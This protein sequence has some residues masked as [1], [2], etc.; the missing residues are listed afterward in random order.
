MALF[1]V[2]E[3]A[4][5]PPN[6]TLVA[7]VKL[8]PVITTLSPFLADVGVNEM[9]VGAGIKVN[10]V[11]VAAPPGVVTPTLP[12]APAP[13]VAVIWVAL[14]T[15]NEVA[16]VPPK[17]TVVAPV[18]LVPVMVTLVPAM[19]DIGVNEVIVGAETKV[20]PAFAAAPP[21]VVTPTLPEAPLAT[22][23]VI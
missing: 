15:V 1:I 4:F 17:V 8:V 19:P 2:K 3:V 7:P 11:L 18:K 13:T 6:L 9:I 22:V 16:A 10:P 12:E 23:A 5:T 20:N 14:F 21:G